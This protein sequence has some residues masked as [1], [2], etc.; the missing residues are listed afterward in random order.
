MAARILVSLCLLLGLTESAWAQVDPGPRPGP[1]GAGG[2]FPTLNDRETAFFN[3][4]RVTF[5]EVDSVS[6][7]IAGENG[8][9]LGPTFNTNSC[10]AC[11][12]QPDVGGTSPHPTLGQVSRR[13][14]EVD[15]AS[16]DRQPGPN[17]TGPCV[18]HADG[19]VRE[20]RFIRNH[21]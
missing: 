14:P 7:G 4:A 17:P 9:G 8:H 16:L 20:A 18:S 10:A 12:A 6:G 2:K 15:M 19:P 21:D 11:H 3:A 5:Q 1:A 13:N